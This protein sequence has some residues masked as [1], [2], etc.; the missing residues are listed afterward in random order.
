MIHFD[1]ILNF[2]M[3]SARWNES[4]GFSA[5]EFWDFFKAPWGQ[6]KDSVDYTRLWSKPSANSGFSC[7]LQVVHHCHIHLLKPESCSCYSRASRCHIHPHF[8]QGAH[9][10]PAASTDIYCERQED[11]LV[12]T[13]LTDMPVCSL[14]TLTPGK[15][16]CSLE[17]IRRAVHRLG[18]MLISV[19]PVSAYTPPWTGDSAVLS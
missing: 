19:C 14:Q 3:F 17:Q 10:V 13:L 16:V 6:G 1:S 7:L 12:C 11:P 2:Q 8:F 4:Q 5:K 15:I 18:Q 9:F